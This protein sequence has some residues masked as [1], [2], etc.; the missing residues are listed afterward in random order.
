MGKVKVKYLNNPVMSGNEVERAV[1]TYI[2]WIS[3]ERK[4]IV[5]K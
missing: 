4:P 2:E 1:H 3:R 5:L